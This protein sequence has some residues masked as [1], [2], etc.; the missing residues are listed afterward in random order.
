VIDVAARLAAVQQR[1][2]DAVRRRGPGPSVRLIGVGKRQ[3]EESIRAAVAAGL[4]DLG[5]NYAQELR[6]RL[7][8]IG[9][10]PPTWHFI[11]A[12]QSNKVKYLVG[13][14]FIHTVDR[15]S[16]LR[17][18]EKRAAGVGTV[19]EALVEVNIG[20]EEGKAGVEPAGVPA[21]L[22]EFAGL[23]HVRCRGLMIIPPEGPPDQTRVHFRAL[24]DMRDELTTTPRPNVD[25]GE[26]SM[27]MSTDY[28]EAIL[29]G[30]TMVRVGTAIFGP[31]PPRRH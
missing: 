7:A 20:L 19:Q 30:S 23:E 2:A 21:L 18:M 15:A 26:L 3:P 8:T 17:A 29:E 11:G 4:Q 25:L 13:K 16:L 27:G 6:D 5:E 12:V 14:T 28:E 24:R 1:I 31:R 10:D 22:D 9:H